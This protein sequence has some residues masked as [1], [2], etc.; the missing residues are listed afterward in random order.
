MKLI[1]IKPQR[2]TEQDAREIFDCLTAYYGVEVG[3]L[4]FE[5]WI[6]GIGSSLL[7]KLNEHCE[8]DYKVQRDE[9]LAVLSRIDF[10]IDEYNKNGACHDLGQLIDFDYVKAAI[11]KASASTDSGVE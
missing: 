6:T 8:P 9:L 10:L 1:Q 3:Q 11:A 5:C 7:D 4:D 2:I